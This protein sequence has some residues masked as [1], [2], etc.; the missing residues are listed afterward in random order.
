MTPMQWLLQE[1]Q[2]CGFNSK[3]ETNDDNS[4]AK[5]VY[6]HP[7]SLFLWE[8]NPN[9]LLIDCTSRTNRF[10]MP[11]FNICGVTGGN[12]VIQLCLIFLSGEKESD[13]D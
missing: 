2:A 7:Q 8:N 6:L 3:Y 10:N 13:Y 1:F 5:L 4:L 12:K 11:L 9:I